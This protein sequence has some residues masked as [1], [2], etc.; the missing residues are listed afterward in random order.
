MVEGGATVISSFLSSGLVDRLIVTV[1][2]TLVGG[3]GVAYLLEHNAIPRLEFL[4]SKQVGQDT[5]MAWNVLRCDP[6]N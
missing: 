4:Q 1:C 3:K 5:V 2:P 6:A